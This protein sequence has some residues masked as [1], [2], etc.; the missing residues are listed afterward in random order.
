M[1]I[2]TVFSR[3]PL[4]GIDDGAGGF[5]QDPPMQRFFHRYLFDHDIHI[6]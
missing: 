6:A 3:P 4:G 5:A 2:W 1:I